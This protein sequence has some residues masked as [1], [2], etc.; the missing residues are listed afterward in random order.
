LDKFNTPLGT[1][2]IHI[3]RLVSSDSQNHHFGASLGKKQF[4]EK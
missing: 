4:S 3:R 2:F 1:Y